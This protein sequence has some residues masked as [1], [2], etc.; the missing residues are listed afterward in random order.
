MCVLVCFCPLAY[1]TQRVCPEVL[2]QQQ[3][4]QAL[5]LGGPVHP[6]C[7]RTGGRGM[8]LDGLVV[9]QETREPFGIGHR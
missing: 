3:S 4:V 9:Q 1:T 2:P 8:H 5:P 7:L 6:S